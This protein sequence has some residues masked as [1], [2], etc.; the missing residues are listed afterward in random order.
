VSGV[1]GVTGLPALL[2]SGTSLISP[3]S[4]VFGSRSS[5]SYSLSGSGESTVDSGFL[6][7]D[8]PLRQASIEDAI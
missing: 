7:E 6:L 3:R 5:T 1:R 4:K 2:S 8:F